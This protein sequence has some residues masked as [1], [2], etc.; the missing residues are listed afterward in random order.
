MWYYALTQLGKRLH[1][2]LI[3]VYHV[4]FFAR[5]NI[6][7]CD[8]RMTEW[9]NCPTLVWPAHWPCVHASSASFGTL[10]HHQVWWRPQ[11]QHTQHAYLPFI[12]TV[13]T[14]IYTQAISILSTH[15]A[16][17]KHCDFDVKWWS[18]ASRYDIVHYVLRYIEEVSVCNTPHI[19]YTTLFTQSVSIIYRYTTVMETGQVHD[20]C[21]GDAVYTWQGA[22][23]YM[24]MYVC[25]HIN[26]L[27][28]ATNV[29]I[30]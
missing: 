27:R 7:R 23:E 14:Y 29:S 20:K 12:S 21:T 28:A 18:T 17:W 10:W 6:T 11:T 22:Q 24:Y 25:V 19:T 5:S 4:T 2:T 15:H 26:S 13:H 16:A 8:I 30:G 9:I 3:K 1:Q